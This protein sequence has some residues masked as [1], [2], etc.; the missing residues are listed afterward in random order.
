MWER[1]LVTL[2]TVPH[3][4]AFG[5]DGWAEVKLRKG[6]WRKVLHVKLGSCFS[7]CKLASQKVRRC[8]SHDPDLRSVHVCLA[9]HSMWERE[10]VTTATVP[11]PS[12][13]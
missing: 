6:M 9:R 2:A 1:E 12:K 8:K 4:S 11:H 5:R 13:S 10:L 7:L 3:P